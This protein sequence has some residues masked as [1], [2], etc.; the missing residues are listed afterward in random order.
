VE[1]TLAAEG[2]D[3]RLRVVESGFRSLAC[4]PEQQLRNADRNRE[5]WEHELGELADYASR[6]RV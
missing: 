2:D 6:A 5:G 3:T 1:F 4:G